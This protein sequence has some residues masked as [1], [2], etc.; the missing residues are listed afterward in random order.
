M[1]KLYVGARVRINYIK[2]ALGNEKAKVIARS[3][4]GRWETDKGYCIDKDGKTITG[5]TQNIA[6]VELLNPVKKYTYKYKRK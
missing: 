3:Q 5:T 6:T 1:N 2:T 4:T